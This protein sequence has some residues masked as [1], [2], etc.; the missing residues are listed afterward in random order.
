MVFLPW[1]SRTFQALCLIKYGW[2]LTLNDETTIYFRNNVVYSVR[3]NVDFFS[4]HEAFIFSEMCKPFQ[5]FSM[6]NSACVD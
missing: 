4:D 1:R 3:G 6:K 2:K 5:H